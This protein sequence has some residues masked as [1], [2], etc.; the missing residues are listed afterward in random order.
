MRAKY[1]LD[2]KKA[3]DSGILEEFPWKLCSD[4]QIASYSVNLFYYF[5]METD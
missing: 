3:D 4:K 5:F 2:S 1:Q